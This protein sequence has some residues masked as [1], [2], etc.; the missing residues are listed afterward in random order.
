MVPIEVEL[1]PL[2]GANIDKQSTRPITTPVAP[3]TQHIPIH[4]MYTH[5]PNHLCQIRPSHTQP[6]ASWLTHPQDLKEYK[7]QKRTTRQ[8][9]QR[10]EWYRQEANQTKGRPSCYQLESTAPYYKVAVNTTKILPPRRT[11]YR[12]RLGY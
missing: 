12:S 3:C 11:L 9:R 8:D 6:N 2:N 10:T 1:V 7:P 5:G 4:S